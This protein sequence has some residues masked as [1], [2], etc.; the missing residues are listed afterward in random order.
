MRRKFPNVK[1]WEMQVMKEPEIDGVAPEEAAD[2]LGVSVTEVEQMIKDD[3][4][5]VADIC[6]D[7]DTVVRSL[8][9]TMDIKRLLAKR[10][11]QAGAR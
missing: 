1:A 6:N 9:R 4:L 11:H 3:V 2:W 10:K 7:T 5:Q 8:V